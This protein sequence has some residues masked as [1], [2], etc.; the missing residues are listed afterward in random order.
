MAPAQ[1]SRQCRDNFRLRKKLCKLHHPPKRLDGVVTSELSSQFSRQC[2]D[3]L[4]AITGPL[5]LQ[6][7]ATDAVANLPVQNYERRIDRLRHAG[8]CFVNQHAHFIEQR[9]SDRRRFRFSHA[10]RLSPFGLLTLGHRKTALPCADA[11]MNS[12]ASSRAILTQRRVKCR[13][14]PSFSQFATSDIL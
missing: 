6:N 1:L 4:V 14:S 13:L 8:P 9:T 7:V 3:N 10:R 2:R 12:L 11:A 5:R